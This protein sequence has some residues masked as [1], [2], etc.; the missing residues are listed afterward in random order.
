MLFLVT[1][2]KG[3]YVLSEIYEA[4][5][6]EKEYIEVKFV[7]GMDLMSITLPESFAWQYQLVSNFTNEKTTG[8]ATGKYYTLENGNYMLGVH[9]ADVTHYV[10]AVPSLT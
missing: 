10:K 8:K 5:L 2:A 6:G 4:L 7:A 1:I 3:V 9:I